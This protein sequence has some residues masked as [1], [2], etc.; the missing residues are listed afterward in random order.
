M[1]K[2]PNKH[3]SISSLQSFNNCPYSY[4]MRY[5]V[6]IKPQQ[7]DKM[8][9][10]SLFQEA[11]N[12]KYGGNSTDFFIDQMSPKVK[13]IARLLIE[14]ANPLEDIISLDKEYILDLGF[15]VPVKFIPDVLTKTS[16]IENKF[17]TGYYSPKMVLKE[18]QR[19]MY[20]L[21]VRKLFDFDPK[22][23]YQLFN[24]VKKSVELIEAP[25]TLKDIDELMD[26]INV[27]MQQV[28]KCMS[29]GVWDVGSHSWCNYEL[30]CPLGS[31]YKKRWN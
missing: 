29:T 23:Y 11:L 12:A 15:D 20:S 21:G 19:I 10:G 25:V 7:K 26:W 18:R 4:F 5:V 6:G 13:E 24:T 16:I 1:D 22:V 31:K 17:T 30:T 2:Y 3:I 8:K 9:D 14:K 28:Y 27:T